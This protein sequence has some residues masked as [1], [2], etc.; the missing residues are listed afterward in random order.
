MKIQKVKP[1]SGWRKRLFRMPIYFYRWGLGWLMPKRFLFLTHIGRKSRQPRYAV[2]EV[3]NYDVA[4][5]I[6][7]IV[8]AYGTQAQWY[9]NLVATP[10]VAV[11]VGR[12]KLRAHA[13]PLTQE[14]SGQKMVE[15]AQKYPKLAAQIMRF[16]GYESD[17]SETSYRQIGTE[18][19]RFVALIVKAPP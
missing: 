6:Y 2:L 19:I 11:Q 15:Y 16:I 3:T 10:D 8:S 12:R 5:D 1:P 9:K 13:E 14:Q 4:N 18:S 17:G 7:Y